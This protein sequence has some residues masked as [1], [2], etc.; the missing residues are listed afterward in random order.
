MAVAPGRSQPDWNALDEAGLDE[1]I[2]QQLAKRQ[3]R[4]PLPCAL[5]RAGTRPS[6]H[7]A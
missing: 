1:A 3:Q 6:S 5:A 4:P 2:D 7:A